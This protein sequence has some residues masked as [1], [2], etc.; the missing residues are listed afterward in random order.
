VPVFTEFRCVLGGDHWVITPAAVESGL[1]GEAEFSSKVIRI[2]ED[3]HG[4]KLLD[5]LIH[6][7]V[8]ASCPYLVEQ[9]VERVGTEL[10]NMLITF[11]GGSNQ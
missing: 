7:S 1:M 3:L 4:R 8:H 11:F 9:E 5:T 6:E 2:C 10:A